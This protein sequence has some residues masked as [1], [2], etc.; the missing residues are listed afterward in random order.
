MNSRR[1]RRSAW[2]APA[3]SALEQARRLV[4]DAERRVA[5]QLARLETIK[6]DGRDPIR[7][8]QLLDHFRRL[9]AIANDQLA[10][11]ERRNTGSADSAQNDRPHE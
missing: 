7:A 10:E 3:E 4:A 1:I 9:L 5:E 2:S 11:Q 6:R 8:N